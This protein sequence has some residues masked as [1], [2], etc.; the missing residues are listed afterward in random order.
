[1]AMNERIENALSIIE[2]EVARTCGLD[3]Q[4]TKDIFDM[5][6]KIQAALAGNGSETPQEEKK[7]WTIKTLSA[8]PENEREEIVENLSVEELDALI[9][10]A[11]NANPFTAMLA[12]L[13]ASDEE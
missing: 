3:S 13:M 1:M 7:G 2:S 5:T 11:M 12:M 8:L 10:E 4:V 6:S 9:M